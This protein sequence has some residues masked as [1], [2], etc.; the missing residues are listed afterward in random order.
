LFERAHSIGWRDYHDWRSDA[1]LSTN[2]EH[3]IL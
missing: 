3:V 1:L 2:H